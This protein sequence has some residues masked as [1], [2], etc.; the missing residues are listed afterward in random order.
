MQLLLQI[1]PIIAHSFHLILISIFIMLQTV[2]LMK[3]TSCTQSLKTSHWWTKTLQLELHDTFSIKFQFLHVS[4]LL[5]ESWHQ[6][7]P[8]LICFS[9]L[10]LSEN[11]VGAVDILNFSITRPLR[12]IEVPG[13]S[14][15][16]A[17]SLRQGPRL[18]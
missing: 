4:C 13:K 18:K 1:K 5:F 9:P 17:V 6:C 12:S 3:I 2:V 16:L 8:H 14:R 11:C 7:V 10:R 15:G